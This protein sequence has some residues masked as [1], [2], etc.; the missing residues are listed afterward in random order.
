[1][2][3]NI[4]ACIN[5][6]RAIGWKNI[7]N[8]IFNIPNELAVFKKITTKTTNDKMNIIVM[9]RNTWDSLPDTKPLIDR[10]NCVISTNCEKLNEK[11][12]DKP[13]FK[14]FHSVDCFINFANNNEKYFNET[15]VI[16]GKSIYDVFF[17]KNI[18]DK[19]ILT[20]IETKNYLGDI[21]FPDKYLC[22]YYLKSCSHYANIKAINNLDKTP[23]VL[24]YTFR[25][26][27]KY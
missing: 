10:F 23:I 6:N 27:E 2:K 25:I 26:Y 12:K 21:L 24:D 18:I 5:H 8:L 17:K 16:G 13:N 15:F 19:L 22:G 20:E 9:G 3:Y 11:Y 7:N 14:A 4:I 1:M